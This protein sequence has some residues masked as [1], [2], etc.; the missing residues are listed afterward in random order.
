MGFSL[1]RRTLRERTALGKLAAYKESLHQ[2]SATNGGSVS[3][4]RNIKHMSGSAMLA[5]AIA[6]SVPPVAAQAPAQTAASVADLKASAPVRDSKG[7]PVATI[8]E[9]QGGNVVLDTGQTK[10]AVPMSFLVKDS[11]GLML[12][13]T[14]DQ[15]NAAIAKAHAR[16]E[17]A[18]AQQPAQPQATPPKP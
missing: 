5:L 10:I 17:A 1:T 12:T 15:F 13:I 14:A 4:A 9:P 11:Q 18:K 16:A 2:V 7:V 3:M 6:F 8:V